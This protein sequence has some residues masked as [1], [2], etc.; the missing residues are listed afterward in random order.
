M[1][2]MVDGDA[3]P[4]PSLR[5]AIPWMTGI[6]RIAVGANGEAIAAVFEALQVVMTGRA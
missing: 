3:V 4:L 5:A 2:Y 1:R 6:D